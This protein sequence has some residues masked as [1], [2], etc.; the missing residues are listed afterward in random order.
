MGSDS[1]GIKI[2]ACNLGTTLTIAKKKKTDTGEKKTAEAEN[3]ENHLTMTSQLFKNQNSIQK[4]V[5]IISCGQASLVKAALSLL[6]NLCLN[7]NEQ[8]IKILVEKTCIPPL[9]DLLSSDDPKVSGMAL[10]SLQNILSK[11]PK[12]ESENDDGEYEKLVEKAGGYEKIGGFKLLKAIKTK[13]LPPFVEKIRSD[14]IS[15]KL[16]GVRGLH[17]LQ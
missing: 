8:Q 16:E 2:E 7:G 17:F 14:D 10:C 5:E 15:A 11:Q 1:K 4:L 3:Q 13:K 12:T 9:C 6:K